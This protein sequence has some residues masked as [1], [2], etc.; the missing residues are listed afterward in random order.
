MFDLYHVLMAAESVGVHV[1]IAVGIVKAGVGLFASSGD[2]GFAV[3]NDGAEID[4]AGFDGRGE[5]ENTTDGEATGI[6]DELLF[7][8]EGVKFG[9]SV[10]SGRE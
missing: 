8:V 4:D 1:V 5:S 6:S 9:E 10:L 3:A 2:A 7:G